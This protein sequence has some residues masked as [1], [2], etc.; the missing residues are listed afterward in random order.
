[1]LT[2]TSIYKI[3]TGEIV[4]SGGITFDPNQKNHQIDCAIA[5]WG[6]DTHALVE[7][8][9]DPQSQYVQ[10]LSDASVI[11]DRPSLHISIDK[12]TISADGVDYL[13]LT[14][15]PDPCEIIIDAP[16]P[17][18]ETTITEVS[19]GGFEFDATTP[20]LYTIEVKRFPFLAF[21]IEITA[22]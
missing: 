20:G 19:G 17:T 11:L 9:S 22:A 5:P 16:D 6:A 15:L 12:T 8:G 13:T 4:S 14:G 10:V 3:S 18:V 2:L 1:M 7:E 21:K